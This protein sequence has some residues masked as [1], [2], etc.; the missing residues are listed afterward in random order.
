[1]T[2]AR[3]TGLALLSAGL[4]ASPVAAHALTRVTPT[5]AGAERTACLHAPGPGSASPP[6]VLVVHGDRTRG[7]PES[8]R[9]DL[10]R[11]AGAALLVWGTC[12]AGHIWPCRDKQDIVRFVQE[13]AADACPE[14]SR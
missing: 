5:V 4:L 7:K 3:R 6:L 1:M 2:A 14:G 9:H 12:N 8:W 13:D 11:L 10:Q